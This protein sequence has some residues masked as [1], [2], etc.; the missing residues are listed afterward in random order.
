MTGELAPWILA[1]T[2]VAVLGMFLISLDNYL[3]SRRGGRG[4][5]EAQD[6]E[7]LTE[8]PVD[9]WWTSNAAPETPLEQLV[10]FEDSGEVTIVEDGSA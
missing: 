9:K 8:R 4:G 7:W 6:L 10:R 2:A 3:A 1:V 5:H